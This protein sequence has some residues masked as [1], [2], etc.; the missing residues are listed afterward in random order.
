M[1]KSLFLVAV[2]GAVLLLTQLSGQAIAGF[3][4]S[5][6][7]IM[8]LL[9]NAW[10]NDYAVAKS[11]W[12]WS[13]LRDGTPRWMNDVRGKYVYELIGSPIKKAT[14][15]G[16]LG[17]T[18]QSGWELGCRLINLIEAVGL[19]ESKAQE[20]SQTLF[21]ATVPDPGAKYYVDSGGIRVELIYY[22]S[23]G[24]F[25]LILSKS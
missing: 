12:E 23:M 13:D 20:I 8:D 4:E 16:E 25:M 10:Q 17:G 14:L 7:Q 3:Q 9:A 15:L 6:W 18:E 19:S 24:A 2:L 21:N 5:R 1:K 22:D 11:G